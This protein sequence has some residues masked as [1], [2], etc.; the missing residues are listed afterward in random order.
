MPYTI[1]LIRSS[2]L[3]GSL[4]LVYQSQSPN[5][6]RQNRAR[7]FAFLVAPGQVQVCAYR[8]LQRSREFQ[9]AHYIAYAY[10]KPSFL[11]LCLVVLLLARILCLVVGVLV[12]GTSFLSH[13][14]FI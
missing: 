4:G 5:Y 7:T 9:Q 1:C 3:I 11:Y 2:V 12:N 10:D 6:H 8:A 13:F 14:L